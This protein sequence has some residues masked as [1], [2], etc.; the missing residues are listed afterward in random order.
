[1]EAFISLCYC[2]L[3][4]KR[5]RISQMKTN[6]QS[7]LL[8]PLLSCFSLLQT[9]QAVLPPPDGGY[10]GHNTAVGENA[11][12]LLT[13]GM[14]AYNTAVGYY[15][16]GLNG[17]ASFNTA[18]GAGALF[19][20]AYNGDGNTG[21]GAFALYNS[22]SGEANTATGGVALFNNINGSFNTANGV[23]ALASNTSGNN[24][25]ADGDQALVNSTI[26]SNNLALGFSAGSAV[27][28]A[29]NVICIGANV[30]GANVNNSCHIGQIFGAT[31]A[32]GI[33][34]IID[35]N[36]R[37]GTALS[38]KRF[39]KQINPMDIASEALFSLKPVTFR[40]KK[41]LDAQGI[42]QFGLVA[43]D[44]ERVNPDLIVRDQEGKPYTVRYDA[45]NVM[46]LNEFLK[47]H[48]KVE[49][50]QAGLA[51]QQKDFQ[52][53]VAR[54]QK[55]IETLIAGLQKVSAELEASKSEPQTVMSNQ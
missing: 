44:V 3:D 13:P 45:V 43:E 53:V 23:S 39:K 21:N 31:I 28:T 5:R 8:I 36:G 15:S 32:G 42:P 51:Q 22:T 10:P 14:G 34:V 26:G 49:A 33:P 40:Y 18:T 4:G 25:T 35:G 11:L 46:L 41:E 48:R 19:A 1:M 2:S 9:T 24:N 52:T 54:Q 6:T 20:H 7:F 30:A 12:Q 17:E 38:S 16:L 27:T 29:S 47:E 50:L 37:L 55:Q